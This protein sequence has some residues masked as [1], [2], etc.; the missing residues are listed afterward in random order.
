MDAPSGPA[1]AVVS[2]GDYLAAARHRLTTAGIAPDEAARDAAL[3]ARHALGWDLARLLAAGRD[4]APPDFPARYEAL[5]AR[6]AAR[7]PVAYIRGVQEFY[8]REFLVSRAVLIPR[9]ETEQLVEA[10]LAVLRRPG[11]PRAPEVV[12][13]GTG[14][15]CVAITLALEA[16]M[17]RVSGTDISAA[18]LAVAAANAARL[19]AAARVT[20]RHGAYLADVLG[21]VDLIVS[22]P[23]YVAET[24]RAGL[25]PEVVGYEPDAALFAG[26]DGLEVIRA[27]VSVAADRLRPGGHL[28]LEIGAGQA[29]AVAALVG[30]APPLALARLDEDLR[31]VPRVAVIRKGRTWG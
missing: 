18:A 1:G 19:G 11:A 29:G 23:P 27:I 21:A 13:V 10:A 4:P 15:G 17:A 9:P 14:S 3:L 31:G 2:L 30:A 7:E 12:D 20:W 22:N 24:E 28:V 5:V 16:P 8:G 25:P 26:A 6:R